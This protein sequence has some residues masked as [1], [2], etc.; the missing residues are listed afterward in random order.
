VREKLRVA[1]THPVIA[2]EGGLSLR[3]PGRESRVRI[4]QRCGIG[5]ALDDLALDAR[6]AEA[7]RLGRPD[8]E[9]LVEFELRRA[10]RIECR[11][12]LRG[13]GGPHGA[14]RQF[15]GVFVLR[16]ILD[17]LG[18]TLR[19]GE[20]PCR[21]AQPR[22]LTLDLAAELL[23]LEGQILTVQRLR[24]FLPAALSLHVHDE[25]CGAWDERQ[26]QHY[27]TATKRSCEPG[28]HVH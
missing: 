13:E 17:P 24:L 18:Q 23:E 26:S 22:A 14:G 21:P 3:S 4:A 15:R 19:L 11:A 12:V 9:K 5:R 16:P 8:E 28:G 27:R 6:A 20:Q 1:T 10:L 2:R 25:Q 7:D